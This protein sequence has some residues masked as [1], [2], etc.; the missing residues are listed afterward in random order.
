MDHF[1]YG[2]IFQLFGC[3]SAIFSGFAINIASGNSNSWVGV[4]VSV[5]LIAIHFFLCHTATL[6]IDSL[7][8]EINK[9]KKN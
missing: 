2:V 6:I 3:G 7:A 5:G 8:M 1:R 9:N 4:A